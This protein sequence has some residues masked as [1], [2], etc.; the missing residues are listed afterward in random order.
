MPLF[1]KQPQS[2][3]YILPLILGIVI[4][5]NQYAHHLPSWSF[6][7]TAKIPE[8]VWQ[9]T[10]TP[11]SKVA[12]HFP[13]GVALVVCSTELANNI[14]VVRSLNQQYVRG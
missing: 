11:D 10:L 8:Q 4:R 5:I 3:S 7:F 9:T 12:R 6:E 1:E 13:F 2:L 14:Q